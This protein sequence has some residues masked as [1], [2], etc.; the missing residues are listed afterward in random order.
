[1]VYLSPRS[2]QRLLVL[3]IATW[4]TWFLLPGSNIFSVVDEGLTWADDNYASFYSNMRDRGQPSEV[5][6]APIEIFEADLFGWGNDDSSPR[7]KF[8]K[9]APKTTRP[10]PDPFPLLSRNPPPK[11][12]LLRA[13]KA[14]R[15]PRRHYP[16]Q[17]PLFV[18]F[19][20][21]WPQLLQCVVSYIAAGWPPEDIYVV[22]NT[23][24]MFANR[25]RNLT[26]QNP[27]YLNHTQLGMLG[28]NII[29][30][31]L[32]EEHLRAVM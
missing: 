1:M 26:L 13:R 29:V 12:S 31:R 8:Y 2:R 17:T 25:D 7:E 16:E 10:V 18:G 11:Q 30:V 19:T 32:S 27:F 24:V 3:A 22:E 20:R 23:G 28:I 14:N 21:N 9:P 5:A 6:Q 15:P 4:S